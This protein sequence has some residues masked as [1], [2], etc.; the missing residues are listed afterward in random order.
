VF[1]PVEEEIVKLWHDAALVVEVISIERC[2]V[3]DSVKQ[4]PL[5][6]IFKTFLDHFLNPFIVLQ[7]L[8]K[9]LF[10]CFSLLE[11]FSFIKVL[12]PTCTVLA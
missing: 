10:L 5:E 3:N 9:P 1:G 7:D 12:I 11:F 4:R 6:R 2:T 8:Q